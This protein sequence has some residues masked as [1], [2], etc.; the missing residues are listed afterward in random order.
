MRGIERR[1]QSLEA[2]RTENDPAI[3]AEIIANVIDGIPDK[4]TK[5]LRV[6]HLDTLL[7]GKD[8]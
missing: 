5:R 6:E 8:E 4:R 3:I 1:V 7:E 2:G